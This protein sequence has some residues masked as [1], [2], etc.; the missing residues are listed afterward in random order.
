MSECLFR[1]CPRL[2]Y[3]AT[4]TLQQRLGTQTGK[5]GGHGHGHGHGGLKRQNSMN[6]GD[7]R[8]LEEQSRAEL[9]ANCAAMDSL[10]DHQTDVLYGATVQLQHV[11]SGKFLTAR[12][13][14]AELVNSALRLEVEASGSSCAHF[15]VVPRFKTRSEGGLV[16]FQDQLLLE[17]TEVPQ[18]FVHP[19]ARPYDQVCCRSCVSCVVCVEKESLPL[20]RGPTTRWWKTHTQ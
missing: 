4:A 16:Y 17:P 11:L 7:M 20:P 18:H 6:A 14:Q 19:S 12:N 1:V 8:F 15:R 2:K 3:E 10:D 5:R 9:A 13:E